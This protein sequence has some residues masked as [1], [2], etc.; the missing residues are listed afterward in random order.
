MQ[1]ILI[2]G[3]GYVGTAAADL[4]HS[5]G[6]LVEGWTHSPAAAAQLLN[7]PYPVT[8][9]DLTDRHQVNERPQNFDLVIHCASTRGGDA[10]SYRRLYFDGVQNLL[11]RFIGSTLLFTSSTSVYAQQHGEHVNEQSPA[12]PSHQKGKILLEAESMVLAR[13]GI[14]ARLAGIHG[15]ARSAI[16]TGFLRG[17]AAIDPENDRFMNHVHRDDIADALMLLAGMPTRQT[18]VYN[19]VDDMP[20]L[21]SECYRW[22]ANKLGR[23]LPGQGNAAGS[24]KRGRSNK[25]VSNTRLRDCGWKPRYPTFAIAMEQ[26][27]LPSFGL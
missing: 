4:F 22:L 16:L 7:K 24:G 20:I 3:C 8:A 26:S 12:E 9:V 2:A 14:V 19:V 25:R 6:W 21:R 13:G 11:D 5:A 15:P 10:E 18:S 1:R 23:S 27:I 17:T